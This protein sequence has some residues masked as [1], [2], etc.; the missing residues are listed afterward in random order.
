MATV[1]DLHGKRIA[2][3]GFGKESV[4]LARF[5]AREGAVA[6]TATDTKSVDQL[7]DLIA[8][9]A[10]LTPSVRLFAGG[11]NAAAWA[12]ADVIFVS[13]GITPG[14]AIRIPGIAE[15]AA[16]GAII[17]N[18]TQLLFE[19]SPAP[20]VGITGSAGK[21]TTTTLVGEMLQT[22]FAN[23]SAGRSGARRKVYVG[24]NM[25]I[26][27]INEVAQMTPD[28]VVVL[29]LSEVQLA[30]LHASPHI[31]VITNITPDHY[32]R[33]PTFEEYVRAKRQ[34]VRD[35]HPGDYAI[36][37]ADNTPTFESAAE[38][39][40]QVLYFSRTQPVMA[41]ADIREDAF[42]LRLPGS[43]PIRLCGTGETRLPGKHNHE[44]ILAAS[45]TAYLAGAMPDAIV[46]VIRT[47]GGVANRIEFVAERGG[48]RYYNDS[49]ATS[50]NRA[51]AALRTFDEPI[52]LI[53]GGKDKNLPWE[54]IASEIVRRVRVVAVLGVSAPKILDAIAVAQA[55]IP[56]AERRLERIERV[57][58]VE[59]A[60]RVLVA[61]AQPGEVVL[62]SPGCASHDM[63]SGFEERGERFAQAVRAL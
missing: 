32:D 18:H 48:V 10:D 36:L 57:A 33:Y 40:A 37:N 9:V 61:S 20:I 27:L 38:T 55:A 63:F 5:A 54:E 8:L 14:F 22:S 39:A 34:I 44:N 31:G 46:H 53:A 26:P 15:A 25:G 42:W 17:S 21:T 3:V 30:R 35:M 19:R 13:P 28:D 50:P 7:A 49:I 4:A 45:L 47:F 51:L 24:G 6:I 52:L 2:L 60:V 43:A 12:D 16:R 62:L 59:D 1:T 29:E 56:V 11:N 58:S 41:G 23:D